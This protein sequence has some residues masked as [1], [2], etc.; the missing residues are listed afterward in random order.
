MSKNLQNATPTSIW[1]FP[2]I[3]GDNPQNGWFI[4]NGSKPHEQIDDLGGKKPLFLE[5]P[6]SSNGWF[7][8]VMSV[9]PGV[10]TRSILN[11]CTLEPM[12][13]VL[14]S[15]AVSPSVTGPRWKFLQSK[16]PIPKGSV[17][18]VTTPPKN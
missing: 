15:E 10:L 4:Y 11:L 17:R 8:I 12:H 3:G 14:Y 13:F 16:G 9:F 2:K 5:I 1:V 18:W 6:I 7:S